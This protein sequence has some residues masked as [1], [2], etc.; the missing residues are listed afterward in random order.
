[1]DILSTYCDA[2]AGAFETLVVELAALPDTGVAWLT[3]DGV[4]LHKEGALILIVRFQPQLDKIL[5]QTLKELAKRQLNGTGVEVIQVG[6]DTPQAMETAD[7]NFPQGYFQAYHLPDQGPL[8]TGP[9]SYHGPLA[10][11]LA[12]RPT[13][14]A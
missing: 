9:R 4:L 7:K 11:H 3:P 13:Q 10:R 2:Q 14:P 6:G 12:Q 1:M 8:W 5:A